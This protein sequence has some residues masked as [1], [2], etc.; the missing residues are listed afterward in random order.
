MFRFIHSSD[1][2]LGARFR[3]FGTHAETLRAARLRT[4]R[5]SLETAREK[6]IT[7]FLIAGDLFEDNQVSDELVG[8]TVAVFGDFP[9]ID[10]Y[11]L[12]GNHDPASGPEA[13]WNRKALREA[14]SNVHILREASAVDLGGA[15]LLAS[16]L[17]QKVSAIDPSLKLVEL[18]AAVPAD[19]IKIGITHGALAIEG[20]HQPNDFP[21]A[22]EAASRAGLDYLA[23]GH[24]HNWLVGTDGGRIVMPGTPEPD[25]FDQP[26]VLE[27]S[28][29]AKIDCADPVARAVVEELFGNV[30]CATS[31][32][33]LRR[34]AD[35]IMPDGFRLRGLFAE[36]P[37][38][39]DERPC[40]GAKG[41][42]RLKAHLQAR[43][44]QCGA[45]LRDL[46]PLLARAEQI[47]RMVGE[48][49]L[50][51]EDIEGDISAASQLK[52]TEAERDRL[53]T[54]KS[55]AETP[56][57]AA[58]QSAI[59]RLAA[60]VV[61]LDQQR[62][63]LNGKL[64]SNERAE[65]A[66]KLESAQRE[67][68][69]AEK[70]YQKVMLAVASTLVVA[71]SEALRGELQAQFSTAAV[72]ASQ[73]GKRHWE[74]SAKLPGM[75]ERVSIL[76]QGLADQH[77]ELRAEPDFDPRTA[78]NASYGKL[79]Q[80]IKVEDSRN[81][82]SSF[83]IP[84]PGYWLGRANHWFDLPARRCSEIPKSWKPCDQGSSRVWRE[85]AGG[86][87]PR[88]GISAFSKMSGAFCCT[89]RFGWSFPTQS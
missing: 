8:Q 77:A 76:R 50:D 68:D 27:N 83:S 86:R 40:I 43:A 74:L 4:L 11:L 15:W 12:P 62:L 82:L 66:Q 70:A 28:L 85:S 6:A 63:E 34:H 72:C 16:P 36:R 32:E 41:I 45:R 1:W 18:A 14:P 13:V 23:V 26:R 22:L 59:D 58:R 79:L 71:R 46:E 78:W 64:Q 33:E 73:A 44:D 65:A 81:R 3:Q 84:C 54:R 60:E 75:E 53:I 38:R 88:W 10:I 48:H 49:R 69:A 29:A 80:R 30:I 24:W 19:A 31:I 51:S 20:R 9:T 56:E 89:G 42:E 2:Q 17:H 35:A 61:A 67:F 37:R 7:T 52:E 87:R 21:I 55:A 47:A 57:L 25:Q 39:Y 5:H